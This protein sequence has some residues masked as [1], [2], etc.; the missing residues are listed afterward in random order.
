MINLNTTW[1]T[2]TLF[3]NLIVFSG[4]CTFQGTTMAENLSSRYQY[5]EAEQQAYLNACQ[6]VSTEQGFSPQQATNLC[7]CTLEQYQNKYTLDQFRALYEAAHQNDKVP[8]EFIKAGIFCA[9]R[10]SLK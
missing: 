5:P 8:T 9:S 4:V 3:T 6:R 10:L 2:Q 7:Q 1:M